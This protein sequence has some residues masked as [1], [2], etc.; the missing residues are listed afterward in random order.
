MIK[1]IVYPVIVCLILLLPVFP[2]S[3]DTIVVAVSGGDYS[4]IQTAVDNAGVGDTINIMPGEY[5][6]SVTIYYPLNIK[7]SGSATVIGMEN[8][9]YSFHIS[10]NGV[11]ISDLKCSSEINGIFI[12]SSDDTI[13]Q[14]CTFEGSKTA[15]TVLE[16]SGCRIEDCNILADF[17]GIEVENSNS[18]TILR[19]LISA[20]ARGISVRSSENVLINGNYLNRCEV[21]IAAEGLIGGNIERN[22]LSDMTG[23]IVFITSEGCNVEGNYLESVIQYLQFFTSQGCTIDADKLEGADYFTVDIF[24]DTLY[25]FGNYS[26]TGHDYALIPYQYTPSDI[27]GYKKLGDAFNLTFI[28]VSET[29]SGHIILE[30]DTPVDELEGYD[31]NTYGLYNI[32]GRKQM[33]SQSTID[34]GTVKTIAVI[35]GPDT[36]NYAFM[37]KEQRGLG[38]IA[39][40]IIIV[41]ALGIL[42]GIVYVRRKRQAIE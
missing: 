31:V 11:T 12:N 2:V 19:N 40:F 34:N 15:I 35:E 25:R 17:I 5:Q 14:N 38:V 30:A 23:G 1:S 42:L 10:S 39:T 7:G 18:T 28:N 32:D 4:D 20:P 33:I 21:G 24:S 37:I 3:A 16:S 29:T 27:S 8:D 9:Q 6:G 13:V 36:G 26:I 22:N 41:T